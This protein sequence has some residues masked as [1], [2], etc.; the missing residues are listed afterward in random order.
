MI[1]LPF[2]C[3]GLLLGASLA[4]CSVGPDFQPPR[5]DLDAHWA[6]PD[7]GRAEEGAV[8][9]RWWDAFGDPRLSALVHEAATLNLDLQS[10]ASRLQ[11]SRAARRVLAADALPAVNAGLD[12]SRARNSQDGLSDPSGRAGDSAY[13]LWQGGFD[14]GWELDLW[15]RVRRQIE[16]A[17]AEVRV[18][19]EERHGVALAVMAETARDYI[20]LRGTQNALDIVRQN[21]EIA[22]RSLRL[23]RARLA[24][25]IATD[26]EVAEAA[27]QVAAIEARLP[28]L[29]QREAQLGNALSLLLGQAPRALQD[30]LREPA[31]VPAG[32]TEVPLG[33]PSELAA[34]RPDIRRAEAELHAATAGIGVARGDFYPRITLSG[35]L[36]FQALQLADF[37]GWDSRRFAFGPALSVP[38]FEGGRLRGALRLR[39]AR[40]QEAA[41]AYQKTVLG[42]WHEVD[43]A[44][45]AYQ[46]E[47]RRR[48]SLGRAVVQSRRALE[49]AQRQYAQGTLDFLDVL[50]LQNS[51]LA[52]QAAQVESTTA[53]SLS[54]V[55]LYKAL[56]G[57]WQTLDEP[58]ALAS[59]S[60]TRSRP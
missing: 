39:E 29:Q 53:V 25:G 24:E 44:L 5:A 22:R 11:Q 20:Q 12:Y 31:P 59:S 26:L 52:N 13:S 60:P 28:A 54:L 35:N 23:T 17:D 45:N 2:A 58:Q 33:L 32:P 51:L 3:A 21:L 34:R 41:I 38:L 9:A 6:L 16:A 43:D 55:S 18:A 36:G 7:G 42:A 37:G 15:G 50:T 56:G 4:A 14:L 47:Q 27:A 48:A 57:G 40:Q 46:A 49:S 8:A 10:A 19:E 30:E 1:R